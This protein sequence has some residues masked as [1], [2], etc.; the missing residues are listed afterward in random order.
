MSG[1]LP[2]WS[3]PWE[4]LGDAAVPS[5]TGSVARVR[6]SEG[7]F[8]GAVDFADEQC[9]HRD[10]V[11]RHQLGP[12]TWGIVA[13]LELTEVPDP[14]DPQY[15]D[16]VLTP[17]LA[18][19][20]YGRQIV[21]LAPVRLGAGLFDAFTDV[22]HRSVWLTYAETAARPPEAGFSDCRDGRSTRTVEEWSILVNPTVTTS[23]VLV[24]GVEV[25][26]PPPVA[27]KVAGPADMSVPH[28]ALP[29][30]SPVVPWLIRLGSVQWD[31][32]AQRLRPA[33]PG[34][35]GEARRYAGAVADHVLAPAAT[36]RLA[37]RTAP[38]DV[39]A[40]EFATVE[41]R[42]RAQGRLTAERELWLEGQPARFT[43]DGG[44]EENVPITLGRQHDSVGTGQQLRLK[45]G[46]DPAS[47]TTA[48]SIGAG[49]GAS[50]A[51]TVEARADGTVSLPTGH[52]SFGGP[53]RQDIDLHDSS[54]GFGT[55]AGVTYSRTDNEFAWFKGG[56]H[57]DAPRNPG[58]G[59]Q[60]QLR[61]DGDGSLDFGARTRQ[62][63]DL[64]AVA[65][66]HNYG[67]GVQPF[68]LYFRTDFDVCWFRGGSH[69]DVRSS[70]GGGGTLAMKLDSASH[71]QVMGPLSS[72]QDLTVGRGGDAVLHTRH[73]FGKA[74]GND[75]ND[76]LYLNY[77]NGR[78]VVVGNPGGVHSD[79]TVSGALRVTGGSVASVVKV[80]RFDVTVTNDGGSPASWSLG[81]AGAFDTVD[82]AV[83]ML[84]GF[85]MSGEIG[86]W[87]PGRYPTVNGIPQHVW[88][89]VDTF[90][91]NGAEGHAFCAES[92]AGGDGDNQVSFT[93]LVIGRKWT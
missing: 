9:Y 62:M 28:Q 91:R 27:G 77:N 64:W 74:S 70:P 89:H 22:A 25:A 75:A 33:A 2:T 81:W 32:V 16:V 7:Q 86:S 24:D 51:T 34:R 12:H 92:D 45:L 4:A 31:G 76:D 14:A 79:L 88:V 49:E 20:G 5:G 26:P 41:G 82:V 35:L 57:D 73:I 80:E 29:P 53:H 48:L 6:Y 52:L 19:D 47:A 60:L 18:V 90:D 11:R 66:D 63:I 87:S 21:V 42:L 69:I 30:D 10:Q 17:G 93:V 78:S 85:S 15:V 59:G 84:T 72:T 1:T 36:L 56:V 46:D 50:A 54:H 23:T 61:L 55:Q 13:G 58:P 68:T 40:A 38:A 37:P 39:D 44:A 43:F 83:P 8:L 71:L 67:I 65:P 3:P